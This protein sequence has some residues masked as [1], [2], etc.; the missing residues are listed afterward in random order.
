MIG[1]RADSAPYDLNRVAHAVRLGDGRIAVVDGQSSEL[2]LFDSTGRFLRHL[3]RRGAG[4]GEAQGLRALWPLGGDTL[5]TYDIL[6][7]R[8]TRVTATG[9]VL[10][11]ITL[12]NPPRALGV[13]GR[14]PGGALAGHAEPFLEDGRTSGPVER[15][16]AF[17]HRIAKDGSRSDTILAVPG[18]ESYPILGRE[19]KYSFPARWALGFGRVT[20]VRV[21]P[22]A[23]WVGTAAAFELARY[24]SGGTLRRLVR[25]AA[26][27][28]PVEAAD[29]AADQARELENLR[30]WRASEQLVAQAREAIEATRYATEF[31]PYATFYV[32]DA[33]ELWVEGSRRPLDEVRR[34]LV[35]DPEGMLVGRLAL[36]PR[37]RPLWIGRDHLVGRSLDED[38]V[39]RVVVYRVQRP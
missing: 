30:R 33:G 20:T 9:T 22:D 32:S 17:L 11:T 39:E 14:L 18:G 1:G 8:V 10:S 16:P 21:T 3:I 29:R 34:Y 35:F 27:P 15:P 38:D 4:P 23:I 24:D 36:P 13:I 26:P 7:R 28:A 25:F 31:P 37:T 19:G 5:E 6:L 12:T 2:R